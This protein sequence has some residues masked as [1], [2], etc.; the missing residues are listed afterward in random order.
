MR[1]DWTVHSRASLTGSLGL[2]T[3]SLE[4]VRGVTSPADG[5]REWS[6]ILKVTVP[7]LGTRHDAFARDPDHWAYWKREPLAYRSGLLADLPGGFGAPQL[8]Q[9]EEKGPEEIWLWLED[10]V[11]VLGGAWPRER[12]VQAARHLGAFNGAYLAGTAG[13]PL[14]R[15]P[16]LGRAYFRQRFAQAERT[17]GWPLFHDPD[18]WPEPLVAEHFPAGADGVVRRIWEKRWTL[19]DELDGLPQ[20]LRHGDAHQ[21]NFIA[22]RSA[23]GH[24]VTVAVDWATMGIGAVGMDL[25]DL[26]LGAVPELAS[27]PDEANALVAALWQG[28]A[29]GLMD[30]GC[31][32]GTQARRGFVAGAALA[33]ASRLHWA[34][35]RVFAD[36]R[37][38]AAESTFRELGV[39]AHA[40]VPV[41]A[42]ALE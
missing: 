24:D 25:L 26:A 7:P 22:S 27:G 41:A 1:P 9:I 36:G 10:V 13:R 17:G 28:Y 2:A 20:T 37:P 30:S 40:F 42:E 3:G 16:W 34:L 35:S 32:A 8:L 29:A 6:A 5:A 19:L 38:A 14:P 11:D 15:E 31:T 39:T 12:Y 33:W 23:T 21:H 4:R 18:T